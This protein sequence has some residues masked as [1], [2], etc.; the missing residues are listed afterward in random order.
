MLRG[1]GA[2][3]IVSGESVAQV[4]L[5]RKIVFCGNALPSMKNLRDESSL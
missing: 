4:W 3:S 1:S 5:T 2:L